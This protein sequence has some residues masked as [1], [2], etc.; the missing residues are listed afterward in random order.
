MAMSDAFFCITLTA[1][2]RLEDRPRF[3]PGNRIIH[4]YISPAALRTSTDRGYVCL[5]LPVRAGGGRCWQRG[6]LEAASSSICHLVGDFSHAAL[7][8]RPTMTKIRRACPL[9]ASKL[10]QSD[11]P[12]SNLVAPSTSSLDA[13]TP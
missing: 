5:S 8:L 1:R 11:W 4:I 2:V 6:S 9:G 10:P 3:S 12:A 7:A 13:H